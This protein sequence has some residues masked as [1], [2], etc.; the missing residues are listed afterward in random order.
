MQKVTVLGT[1]VL[2]SQIM[3]Q[4]AYHGKDVVGYDVKQEFLDKL[5]ARWE[6]MR[7]Y[8]R[9][10]VEDYSDEKFQAAIDRIS[11][12]TDL[13]EAVQDA[14][15]VIEA[16]PEKLELKKDVWSQVGAAVPEK[17]VFA[18]NSSTLLP[19]DFA[20]ASGRPEKFLALHFANMVWRNNTGE[21][22]G[23]D[24]TDDA[25]ADQ[26]LQFAQ[27]IGLVAVKVLR[28]QSG[29]LLSNL[30]VPWLDAAAMSYM[31]GAG[32][33]ADIDRI[34]RT[35]TGAPRGPFEVFDVMGFHVTADVARK[36]HPDD[37]LFQKWGDLLEESAQAGRGGLGDGEGF[38]RY[39][40]DGTIAGP[41]EHIALQ[42]KR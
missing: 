15:L 17:T 1:G 2:G 6:W 28:E 35:A 37:E 32:T 11:T 13:A 16:V 12:T 40:A 34:W 7:G 22:M 23:H 5:P 20:D 30:L 41:S 26:V 27:E 9:D 18:T 24:G 4:A 31:R 33:P 21:V 8:Y 10:E 19:S 38:Y 14:D 3:M 42:P 29:Y 25:V 36:D 39:N